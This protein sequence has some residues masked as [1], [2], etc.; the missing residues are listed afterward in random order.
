MKIFFI[1]T[2]IFFIG[3]GSAVFNLETQNTSLKVIQGSSFNVSFNLTC[4]DIDCEDFIG[5]RNYE[6][7]SIDYY[8]ANGD[9]TMDCFGGTCLAMTL[10][11]PVYN[12]SG[13]SNWGAGE[14]SNISGW[15][16]SD[17]KQLAKSLKYIPGMKDI[18]G[19]PV[20]LRTDNGKLWDIIFN[21]WSSA[22]SDEFGYTRT[23]QNEVFLSKGFSL[24]QGKMK[25]NITLL[26]NTSRIVRFPLFASSLGTFT[27]TFYSSDKEIEIE[28][29]VLEEISLPEEN[30][31][32]EDEDEEE[33]EDD[34]G[35]ARRY[36]NYYEDEGFYKMEKT[37]PY[38]EIDTNEEKLAIKLTSDKIEEK[39]NFLFIPLLAMILA[40]LILIAI[41][42]K[43]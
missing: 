14:C 28:I 1:F 26:Q 34:S 33:T 11:G 24:E 5:I 41:L 27:L 23:F 9:L 31:E 37:S 15:V 21:T 16:G 12:F 29:N 17:L 2:L 38:K 20:C 6:E 43:K 25:K 18:I 4:S 8:H 32:D 10:Q 7:K 19:I 42:K 39:S 35:S 22:G 30:E 13:N 36:S 40:S 3:L